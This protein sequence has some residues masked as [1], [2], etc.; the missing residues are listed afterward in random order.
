MQPRT[1]TMLMAAKVLL[2]VLV[3]AY[4]LLVLSGRIGPAAKFGWTEFALIAL[5]VLFSAGF[6]DKVAK[7]SLGE[8]GLEITLDALK[9]QQKAQQSDLTA[10]KIA[11]RGLVTKYEYRHLARLNADGSYDVQYGNKF[12]DEITRLDDIGYIKPTDSN[13]QGFV[14][15]REKFSAH[16]EIP[17][18]LKDYMQITGDGKAYLQAREHPA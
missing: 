17:F 10:I 5:V 15:I 1:N 7:F 14:T 8:K 2:T 9:D 12:F 18:N 11:L 3:L 4:L 16:P 13:P 6:L